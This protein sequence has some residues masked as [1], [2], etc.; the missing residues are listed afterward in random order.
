MS[1]APAQKKKDPPLSEFS[2]FSEVAEYK[3]RGELRDLEHAKTIKTCDRF[4]QA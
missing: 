3:Q 1:A 2:F 4:L